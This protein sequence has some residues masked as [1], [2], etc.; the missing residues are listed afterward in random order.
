MMGGPRE[1]LGQRLRQG[2]EMGH[3]VDHEVGRHDVRR[4]GG[5]IA[6]DGKDCCAPGLPQQ[7]LLGLQMSQENQRLINKGRLLCQDFE[8]DLYIYGREEVLGPY[9]EMAKELH[10][11]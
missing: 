1:V 11:A 10:F 2:G 8:Y 3:G 7:E 9:P 6:A 5:R 4:V